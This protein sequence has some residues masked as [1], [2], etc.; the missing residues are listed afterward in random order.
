MADLTQY[1]LPSA[2]VCVVVQKICAGA[3]A[4]K[5]GLRQSFGRSW[6]LLHASSVHGLGL[7]MFLSLSVFYICVSSG[8]C[9]VL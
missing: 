3:Q 7:T 5:A 2:L 4:L 6:V 1:P 9:F 8:Y